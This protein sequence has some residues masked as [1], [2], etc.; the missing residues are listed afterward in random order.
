MLELALKH[1]ESVK[2]RPTPK[3]DRAK[4]PPD[5]RT[6]WGVSEVRRTIVKPL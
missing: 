1:S 3:N 5:K 2:D 4:G 6:P